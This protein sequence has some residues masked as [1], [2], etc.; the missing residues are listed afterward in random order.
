MGTVNGTPYTEKL[1]FNSPTFLLSHLT[2]RLI[3]RVDLFNR[4]GGADNVVKLRFCENRFYS[5][6]PEAVKYLGYFLGYVYCSIHF[7]SHSYI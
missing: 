2:I 5:A 3:R 4:S 7:L 6:F 1:V